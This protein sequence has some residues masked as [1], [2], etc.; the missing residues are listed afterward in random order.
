MRTSLPAPRSRS[1]RLPRRHRPPR[2]RRLLAPRL[3]HRPRLHQSRPRRL[4]P[5]L[6]RL[7]PRRRRRHCRRRQP[8][9][10]RLP[11]GLW[12]KLFQCW[13]IFRSAV[14]MHLCLTWHMLC[15]HAHRLPNA[16]PAAVPSR[17][18]RLPLQPA[19]FRHRRLHRRRLCQAWLIRW[20]EATSPP[21]HRTKPTSERKGAKVM[22][23][24]AR[25][26]I[27]GAS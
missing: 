18:R 22:A 14:A 3:P 16:L 5:H 15:S 27:V 10:R 6:R 26:C 20:C 8:A 13:S 19:R 1:W 2:L 11:G 25:G 23:R 24:M 7:P 4:R 12:G 9:H 21:C 17:L